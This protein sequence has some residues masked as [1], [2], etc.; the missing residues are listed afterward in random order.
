MSW[1]NL[2]STIGGLGWG[3]QIYGM[4][5]AMYLAMARFQ[6]SSLQTITLLSKHNKVA[7]IM[8]VEF[9][10][11]RLGSRKKR[12]RNHPLLMGLVR[13]PLQKGSPKGIFF[14]EGKGGNPHKG[15]FGSSLDS[16]E[17]KDN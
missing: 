9:N 12:I 4:G 17:G 15:S 13:K 2:P 16:N 5:S 3:P 1:V 10:T 11:F 8:N 14:V 7:T 6:L